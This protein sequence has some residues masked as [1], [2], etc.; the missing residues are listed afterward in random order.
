MTGEVDV[1][2]ATTAFGMGIDKP[3]VRFVLHGDVADS[4][5]SYYQ[6][7]GR[8]GRDGE[9]AEATLFYRSADLGLRRFLGAGGGVRV[10]DVEQVVA[11]IDEAGGTAG[12]DEVHEAVDLSRRKVA[13]ALSRLEDGD[14]IELD[15]G[16]ATATTGDHASVVEAIATS[17]ERR[18]QVEA[19][20]LEM[21]R[22]YAETLA[23][24]RRFLLS[25]FGENY[26]HNCGF[27]DT[28]ESGSAAKRPVEAE[29]ARYPQGSRVN[30]SAWGGGQVVRVEGDNVTVLFDDVGYKTLSA[31]LSTAGDLLSVVE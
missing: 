22:G 18:K 8:A 12:I 31:E 24:R 6:E 2:V 10:D 23:C 26:D 29:E 14:A 30:H 7:I 1:V 16:E 11:A 13:L 25:Y 9:Q 3:D 17:E 19:S 28:C 21:M 20:R 4:L 5:D 27:C 15:A